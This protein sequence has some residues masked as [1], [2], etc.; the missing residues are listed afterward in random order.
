MLERLGWRR[1]VWA[2][3]LHLLI[4]G[5]VALLAAVLVLAVWYPREYSVLAGGRGLFW[6]LVSVDVV[7]GPLLTLVV[8]NE[9]KPRRELV[10]DLGVI[11]ALQL[12]AL[13]YGLS[14]VYQARP[15]ALVFE[16]DRFRVVS[17][18]DVYLDELPQADPAYHRL[19]L[20]GPWLLGTRTSGSGD[21]R[22]KAIDLA[23]KG[24]DL[25]QRPTYWRPYDA[26]R[27]DALK[28]S[29]PVSALL[30]K[31]PS[32]QADISARVDALR[33]PVD[34]ARF[35]PIMARADW[36]ALLDPAGNLVGFAPYDGFF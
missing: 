14:T 10:R 20:W 31:Y 11:G 30:Q 32:A 36:V 27:E 19:P 5:A 16:V 21:E 35:L 8:F 7:M 23:M 17:A 13:V 22:L 12:A 25:G 6:L 24:Y 4:S 15:V 18:A 29:R 3:G 26:S 28:R 34:S 1:R 2:A 9:R 33:L